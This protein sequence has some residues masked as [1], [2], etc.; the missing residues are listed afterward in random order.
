MQIAKRSQRAVKAKAGKLL[1][2]ED[3]KLERLTGHFKEVLNRPEPPQSAVTEARME[4]L[5]ISTYDLSREEISK[6]S[7]S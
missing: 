2:K 3:E 7:L 1:A 5:P 4:N 6:V